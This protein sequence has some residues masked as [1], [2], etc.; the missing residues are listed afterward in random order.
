MNAELLLFGKRVSM[1]QRS[2]RRLA[3]IVV[4]VVLASMLVA[5]ATLQG[6]HSVT[7]FVLWAVVFACR[8]VLG[9]YYAGGLVKPFNGKPPRKPDMPPPLLALK[10]RVYRPILTADEGRYRNDE[11]EL[12]QRNL[13]HYSAYKVLGYGLLVPW[14]AASFLADRSMF[15]LDNATVN[16]I[17]AMML[18]ALMALYLTLPQAILLWTE[19]DMEPLS[20]LVEQ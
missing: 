6:H 13:A 4:Y 18:L 9:G 12:D 1:V 5:S 14:F 17:C 15:S 16:R 10:L 3:V 11:R 19:P 8:L 20:D 7:P 2:R